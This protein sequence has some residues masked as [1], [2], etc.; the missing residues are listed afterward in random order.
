MSAIYGALESLRDAARRRDADLRQGKTRVVVQVGH[1]SQ[2]VGAADVADALSDALPAD[3]YMVI[4][5]CDGACFASPPVSVTRPGGDTQVYRNVNAASARNLLR[6]N[7]A[8]SANAYALREGDFF[9][10]QRRLTLEGCGEMDAVCIDDYLIGGGYSGLARAL[11]IS[12][13]DVI[14]DVRASGLRGRGGAYF[15]AA[16]KWQGA[17]AVKNT[18]RYVVVNCEEGEPGIFPVRHLMEGSAASVVGRRNHR[19]VCVGRQRGVHLHQCRS[20]LVDG[21]DAACGGAGIRQRT[22]GR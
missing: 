2:A 4:A 20:A 13:D 3:A 11:S 9:A 7:A 16:L 15:P 10:K 14:E 22:A 21:T 17:R 8:A 5:G 6:D 18:P 12:Q 1:C 19:G